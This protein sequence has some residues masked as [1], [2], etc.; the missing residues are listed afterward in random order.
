[1]SKQ[2]LDNLVRIGTLKAE[3]PTRSEFIGMVELG[4]KRL[5]DARNETLSPESRFMLAY[6]AAHSLALAAL[7]R[8]G[9]RSENRYAV[10]QALA[11]TTNL[12]TKYWRI[13]VKCHDER[14]LAEYRGQF[15]IDEQLLAELIDCATRLEAFVTALKP[16]HE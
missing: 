15:D 14:N 11:H 3:P 12:E 7:R 2:E 6:E 1:M 8:E 5:V 9:Y 10:F 4:R 16:P 13:F